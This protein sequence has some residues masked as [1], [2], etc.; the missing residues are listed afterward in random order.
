MHW[1]VTD[2]MTPKI[3]NDTT[4]V[5]C[6]GLAVKSASGSAGDTKSSWERAAVNVWGHVFGHR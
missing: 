5:K 1:L 4:L 3:V 6:C 2:M